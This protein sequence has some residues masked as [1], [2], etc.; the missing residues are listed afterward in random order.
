MAKY[1]L[2]VAAPQFMAGAECQVV[3]VRIW[4]TEDSYA[5]ASL[6]EC[7]S[8]TGFTASLSSSSRD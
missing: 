4:E 2:E 6:P 1:L 7:S 8:G 3:R 5:E